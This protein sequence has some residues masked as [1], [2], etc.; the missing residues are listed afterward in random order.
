MTEEHIIRVHTEDLRCDYDKWISAWISHLGWSLPII[1]VPFEASAIS[2]PL[3]ADNWRKSPID[4]PDRPLVKFFITGLTEGFPIGFKEQSKPLRSSKRNLSCA[5]QHPDTVQKYL[6]EKI[7]LGWV[8]G[9]FPNSLAQQVQVN[10][11]G[12]IPKNHQPDKWRLIVDLS[13]PANGSVNGGIPKAFC[14]LKYIMIDSAIE[15]IKQIF[16]GTLLAKIDIKSAFCLLPVHPADRHLLAMSPYILTSVYLSV[17]DLPPSSL[18]F[19]LIY[20][21]GYF[22]DIKFHHSFTI[23][24]IS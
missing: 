6:A 23:S 17:L 5:L 1:R 24:M 3:N 18:M 15:Y 7:T 4:H 19:W 20:W 11:L 9:P 14:S 8:A 21:H 2:S 16:Q 12:V 22:N 10:W 13:H